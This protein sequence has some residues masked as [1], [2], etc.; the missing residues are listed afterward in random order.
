MSCKDVSSLTISTAAT[1]LTA[2][3]EAEEGQGI[4]MLDIPNTFLQTKLEQQD[5][6]GNRMIMKIHGVVVDILIEMDPIYKDLT[7]IEGTQKVLYIHIT[8]AMYGLLVLAIL[9]Y[10]KLVGDLTKYGFR[11]LCGQ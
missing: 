11:S 4:M 1:L 5:K 2:I 6:D 10:K 7:I 9:F 8:R 3:I